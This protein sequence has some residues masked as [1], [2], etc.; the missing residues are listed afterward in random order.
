M[1]L[2]LLASAEGEHQLTLLG[3]PTVWFAI[4][5]GI[6]FLVSLLIT[7]SFSGRGIAR[8]HLATNRLDAD[9][10]E[11]LKTYNSKRGHH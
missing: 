4:I 7:V 9:E 2:T 11:A 8:E 1:D 6:I 3:L 10:R 5:F